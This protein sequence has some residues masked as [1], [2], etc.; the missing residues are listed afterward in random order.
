MFSRKLGP[1]LDVASSSRQRQLTYKRVLAP[2]IAI[3]TGRYSCEFVNTAI[4]YSSPLQQLHL[5]HVVGEDTMAR[6]KRQG[7]AVKIHREANKAK[8]K[9][10]STKDTKA[11][12]ATAKT[13]FV[14]ATDV[15]ATEHVVGSH[16]R[17]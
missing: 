11:K 16:D 10:T 15:K 17:V 14:E 13:S 8:T 6:P 4:C 5:S 9:T 12:D 3:L 2:T 1:N 7:G